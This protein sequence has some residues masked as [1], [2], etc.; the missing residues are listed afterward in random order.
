MSAAVEEPE[1]DPLSLT[2]TTPLLL[3]LATATPPTPSLIVSDTILGIPF[4][5][6]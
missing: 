5:F 2:L 4:S 3:P 6:S 1:E